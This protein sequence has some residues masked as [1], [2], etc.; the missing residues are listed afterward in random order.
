MM[1]LL[2][3]CWTMSE[4]WLQSTRVELAFSRVEVLRVKF[5]SQ[6]IHATRLRNTLIIGRGTCTSKACTC[7]SLPANAP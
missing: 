5:S 6:P 2:E 1:L 3:K 4:M 7:S